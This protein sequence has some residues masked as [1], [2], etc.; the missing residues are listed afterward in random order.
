ML[1]TSITLSLFENAGEGTLS[2][3][4]YLDADGN[5]KK[6]HA[7]N[8]VRGAVKRI[9]C[10]SLQDVYD[11]MRSLKPYQAVSF[12]VCPYDEALVLSESAAK[13]YTGQRPMVTRTRRNFS[14]PTGRGVI[15]FDY[16]PLPGT[17]PMTPEA[18][19]MALRHAVPALRCVTLAVK[20]SV[21]SCIYADDGQEL[22]GISGQHVFAIVEDTNAIPIIGTTI[23]ERLWLAGYGYIAISSG[24]SMLER[25][26]IDG[27][28]WQP[29]RLIFASAECEDGIKQQF[30]SLAIFPGACDEILGEDS[31]I[32]PHS[33][34]PLSDDEKSQV[35]KLKVDARAKMLLAAQQKKREW[36]EKQAKKSAHREGKANDPEAITHYKQ[37]FERTLEEGNVL[38]PDLILYPKDNGQVTVAEVCANPDKWHRHE[39]ADPMEP[40]YSNHD[41]R[42]A[43]AYLKNNEEPYLYSHAHHGTYYYF[44]PEKERRRAPAEDDFGA[45]DIADIRPMRFRVI[46]ADEFANG[47]EPEW[48]IDDILPEGELAMIY[49]PSGSGK[50]FFILDLIASIALGHDWNG[51]P[52]KQGKVVYVAA[53]GVGGFR[54][55]IQA[56]EQYHDVSLK[57]VLGVIEEAPNFLSRDNM[58]LARSINSWGKATVIVVDT[59]AQTTPGADENSSEGIGKALIKCKD[60]SKQTGAIVVL[61]H[62]SGKDRG[63]GARG[64]SGMKAALD[65]EIEIAHEGK[66]RRA[67]ITK[68]KDGE[69]GKCFPFKL[70]VVDLEENAKG[71]KK[72]SCVVEYLSPS[73][74]LQEE[75]PQSKWGK[76]L[77]DSYQHFTEF[78]NIFVPIKDLIQEAVRRDTSGPI[79]L[80]PGSRDRRI[81]TIKA[82]FNN[83]VEKGFFCKENGFAYIPQS[84]NPLQNGNLWD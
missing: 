31:V 12:G 71:K 73:S 84:H 29:E 55:R 46:D 30:P 72:S 82:T 78:G 15:L 40:D 25:T 9:T 6:R 51:H 3:Y 23:S 56:Y 76:N 39:F 34:L 37:R 62:H 1:K 43:I 66:I 4:L 81:D 83:L 69:G 63:R 18:L 75:I 70:R 11:F 53:E 5:L 2:K 27:S 60:L 67:T 33:I 48:I 52:V 22:R 49:G 77:Y 47:P 36:I 64:W 19:V 13:E 79:N 58:D 57:N 44:R 21:S 54:K 32:T 20:P 61:I 50:T 8:L 42:I 24:G 38:P 14:W 28:V 65:T 59:L 41:P 80:Q 10:S 74:Q 7:A 26:I 17:E 35:A 16:D 45:V 68:Q